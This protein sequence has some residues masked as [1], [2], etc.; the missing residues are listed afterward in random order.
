MDRY[1]FLLSDETGENF[2]LTVD[3]DSFVSALEYIRKEYT[4]YFVDGWRRR[5]VTSNPSHH[6][7]NRKAA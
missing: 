3:T 5:K 2:Y 6:V 4:A 7:I 1:F